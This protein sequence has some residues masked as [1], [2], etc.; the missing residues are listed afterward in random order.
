MVHVRSAV[1]GGTIASPADD[2][3]VKSGKDLKR[4]LAVRSGYS[5]FR[6]RLYRENG[7][8]IC[9][10][11]L[12]GDHQEVEVVFLD[13]Q[14][15]DTEKDQ[16]LIQASEDGDADEM[17]RLLATPQN[18]E[19][20]NARGMTPL[21]YASLE[22]HRRC[23][24]L[25]LEAGAKTDLPDT[26][27]LF[28]TALHLAALRGQVEV[29]ALLIDA[30]AK[31]EVIEGYTPLHFAC[32]EGQTE[33]ARVLLGAFGAKNEGHLTPMFHAASHGHLEV[34]RLMIEAKAGP[35]VLRES[36]FAAA[37]KGHTEVV[38]LLLET[39]AEHGI[40]QSTRGE[41][42]TPLHAAAASGYLEVVRVLIE[43]GADTNKATSAGLT[44]LHLAAQ[45]GHQ[46]VGQFLL[47]S[48]AEVNEPTMRRTTPLHFAAEGGHL[49][50]VCMLVKFGANKFQKRSNGATPLQLAAQKGH[51][52]ILFAL[53][54]DGK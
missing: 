24:C 2:H 38:G 54:S 20:R 23:V 13:F 28:Y 11:D 49:E 21:H 46:E 14:P 16:K 35:E 50:F 19:V 4:C 12:I 8:E 42:C 32:L 39:G 27:G 43:F 9:D 33:A 48:Q 40:G 7:I 30:G 41:S 17:E 10:A 29:I 22:G 25:L 1:S 26:S 51:L 5:R 15:S 6:Q 53:A 52:E 36:L 37:C 34:L 18:P 45:K 47:E 31:S 3:E 44:P